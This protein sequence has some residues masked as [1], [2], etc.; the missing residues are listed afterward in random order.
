MALRALI[1]DLHDCYDAGSLRILVGAGVWMASGLPGWDAL[2]LGL[3]RAVIESDLRGRCDNAEGAAYVRSLVG[4]DSH[5]AQA[6]YV[7]VL[8]ESTRDQSDLIA[9]A[10]QQSWD[11]L[12][13]E[14][15]E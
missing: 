6:A 2:N 7:D 3:L 1:E 9:A 5:G 8:D 4:N 15:S 10:I 12:E 14:D 13:D 11:E